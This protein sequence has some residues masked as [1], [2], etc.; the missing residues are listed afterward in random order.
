MHKRA[1]CIRTRAHH[2]RQR[3][4]NIRKRA[5]YICECLPQGH[6]QMNALKSKL[7]ASVPN[8][9]SCYWDF[10]KGNTFITDY[11]FPYSWKSLSHNCYDAHYYHIIVMMHTIVAG[12]TLITSSSVSNVETSQKHVCLQ[13]LV[14]VISRGP[15]TPVAPKVHIQCRSA[16]CCVLQCVAVC[17]SVL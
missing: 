15:S 14:R 4:L 6:Q 13:P 17:C 1:L 10:S 16:C 9:Q 3:A 12:S 5:L 11:F 2:I 8:T 7:A